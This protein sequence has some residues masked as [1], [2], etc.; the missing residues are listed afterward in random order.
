MAESVVSFLLIELAQ[1]LKE[2]VNLQRGVKGDIEYVIGELEKMRAFLRVADAKEEGDPALNAWVKQVRDVADD[3]ED[4]LDE[5]LFR[6]AANS[7]G[8]HPHSS[9]LH[10]IGSAAKNWKARRLI[11]SEL[12]GIKSRVRT[13]SEGH[14]R[15]QHKW[16]YFEQDSS[17][18][19]ENNKL[20][21]FR[22]DAL[23]LEESQVVGISGPTRHLIDCLLEGDSGFRVL[24]IAGMGGLGKTTLAKKVYEDD[25]VKSKFKLR[26]WVTISRSYKLQ[27]ILRDIIQQL[28]AEGKQPV[29]R[30]I[31]SMDSHQL[32]VRIHDL[33]QNER[34]M[35][36]FDN[37]WEIDDWNQLKLSIPSNNFASR[38][39]L[40]TRN[41]HVASTSS[42]NPGM[43]YNLNPLSLTDSWTL[44]CKKAFQGNSCPLHLKEI[45]EQILE[46]CEGLPLAIIAVGGM[47]AT[48]V[49]RIEE[50]A[51][52]QHSLNV[53]TEGNQQLLTMKKI[54]SLSF[55]DLP[56]YLKSC[57]LYTSI[58]PEDYLIERMRL[59]RLWICEGFVEVKEG[60]T[61]EEVAEGYLNELLSRSFIQIAETTSDGRVKWCRMHDLLREIIVSKSR[62]QNFVE[63]ISNQNADR[64][65]E[66]SRRLSIIH[67]VGNI[68]EIKSKLLPRLRSL[69]LFEAD[70]TLLSSNLAMSKLLGEELMLLNV[71]DLRGAPLQIFP[72]QITTLFLL[73]YLSLRNT[74]I[75]KLPTSIRKLQ[76][77]ETLDLKQTHIIELPVEIVKLQKLRHLLVCR[78]EKV[79]STSDSVHVLK[80][81]FPKKLVAEYFS[82]TGSKAP[83]G[84]GNFL[85]LQKL[86]Y[87]AA[88]EGN[89]DL[90]IE[91]GKLTQ[92]RKLGIVNLRR[93]HGSALCDS[94]Q[95][96]RHLCSLSLQSALNEDGSYETL[97]LKDISS[98]PPVLQRLYLIG[99]LEKIPS[100][101][102]SN[103]NLMVLRLMY[104]Q[105]EEDPFETLALP[106][107]VDLV[108]CNAFD[109]L[110]VHIKHG[111]FARLKYFWYNGTKYTNVKIGEGA[112]P[113]FQYSTYMDIVSRFIGGTVQ[114][115]SRLFS[116]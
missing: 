33:L 42:I 65:P 115:P 87:I 22:V 89:D 43:V 39:M 63:I 97:D 27:E 50:W 46:R 8:D 109:G 111:W 107:L 26:A 2:E 44:F 37:V 23:L 105:L 30:G 11:A 24:S 101:V 86:C 98:P 79:D 51:R 83:A 94:I 112:L 10:K 31:D 32:R 40:T 53:K 110:E 81:V 6:L 80:L 69:L 35:I 88:N 68:Y 41:F 21:D 14:Q 47:L 13:M 100:W 29:P 99:K 91:L 116:R 52:V 49:G 72:E 95:K 70:D 113:T 75:S 17:L 77:L 16:K 61:L 96:M 15:Y 67:H 28:C 56:Y 5:F 34:Y 78:Y 12:Q 45:S 76:N 55:N 74:E 82:L 102:S 57:F 54:I 60:R 90:I 93:Q 71:L 92:L 36:V 25:A 9:T 103:E 4:I 114:F 64:W 38:V 1:F 84:F 48:K 18:S 58:F 62:E 108:L 59:I 19:M 85:S 73:R 20:N 3:I 106:N 7:Y 104:S 66:R